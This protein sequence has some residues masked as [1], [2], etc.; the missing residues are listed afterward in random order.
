MR[1]T[2]RI[3]SAVISAMLVL[4]I[5]GTN[6]PSGVFEYAAA[7]DNSVTTLSASPAAQGS[8]WALSINADGTYTVTFSG[9][10]IPE[11]FI[12]SD[13]IAPYKNSITKVVVGE[14]VSSIGEAAFKGCESLISVDFEKN[15]VLKETG[16]SVFEGCTN[17]KKVNLENLTALEYIGTKDA[18]ACRLF[19]NSGLESVIIPASVKEIGDAAFSNSK[20][21]KVE[22][23]E[24]KVLT[25]LG[26]KDGEI[27]ANCTELTDID[28]TKIVS[29]SFSFGTGT[30]GYYPGFYGCTSLESITV[31]G[32]ISGN[33]SRVFYDCK[34]LKN[35][36]FETNTNNI[37]GI[38]E[39]IH[40]TKVEV[41]DLTPLNI[42]DINGTIMRDCKSVSTLKLPDTIKNVTESDTV[43]NCPNLKEIIW[44]KNTNGPAFSG[45]GNFSGNPALED[46]GFDSLPDLTQITNNMFKGDVSLERAVIGDKVTSIGSG[47][48]SG[49][50]GLKEVVYKASS[51]GSVSANAFENAG[52]FDLKLTAADDGEF[53]SSISTDLLEAV[54]GHI[55]DII[56]DKNVSFTVG[57]EENNTGLP[58]P[59]TKGG[60][61]CTDNYGNVYH[62]TGGGSSDGF[63]ELVYGARNSDTLTIP[64]TVKCGDNNFSV[65]AI[66]KDAFKGSS[67]KSL[68]FESPDSITAIDDYAFA[69]AE[70]L[71]SINSESTQE[72]IK[73]S[74][75]GCADFG[76]NLFV[77]TLI[78]KDITEKPFENAEAKNDGA[79]GDAGTVGI[80]MSLED[81]NQIA[82][83]TAEYYTGQSAVISVA[84]SDNVNGVYRIYVRKESDGVAELNGYKLHST[85]DPNIWY[86]ELEKR[87]SGETNI[88]KLSLS[89]PNYTQ[90][91]RKMQVWGVKLS[92][93]VK[94]E[95]VG[96]VIEPGKYTTADGI[97]VTENYIEPTWIA[98]EQEF[99]VTK[100]IDDDDKKAIGFNA[101]DDD[102]IAIKNLRYE[103]KYSPVGD[104]VSGDCGNDFVK[105]VD[106]SDELTL[107]TGLKW[108]D[109]INASDTVFVSDGSSS[110]LYSVIDGKR[111]LI[112]TISGFSQNNGTVTDM[113]LENKDGKYIIHFRVANTK[114]D[115]EIS[116]ISG[117]I[118]FGDEVIFAK[119]LTESTSLKI[120]NNIKSETNYNFAEKKDS[121]DTADVE[122]DLGSAKVTFDKEMIT[123]TKPKYMGE[124]VEFKLTV[125]NPSP[126]E[127]ENLEKLEDTLTT[128]DNQLLYIKP[129]NMQA[130]FDGLH[131]EY[132]T[133]E[134]SDAVI[135]SPATGQVTALDGKTQG[136]ISAANTLKDH[137]KY[138][139]L[140]ESG[141]VNNKTI[142]ISKS[143]KNIVVETDG[144]TVTVG[145]SGTYKTIAEALD[146]LAYIVTMNDNYKLTWDYPDDYKLAAG[147]K[148]E[149]NVKATTKNSLMYLP[150]GDSL[151]YYD[152]LPGNPVYYHNKASLYHKTGS[153]DEVTTGQDSVSYDLS[154]SKDGKVNGVTINGNESGKSHKLQIGDI[155]DYSVDLTHRGKSCYD[156]LP[157][158][159]KMAGLQ[160]L[161]VPA[162]DNPELSEERL[163][164]KT[165][166]GVKYYVLKKPGTYKNIF[167][168]G[169][170]ADT[171]TVNKTATG[172][173][174]L[175][176]YYIVNDPEAVLDD[177]DGRTVSFC[178]KAVCDDEYI[179]GAATDPFTVNNEAWAN[180][181]PGHRI[182][183][184]IFTGGAALAYYKDIVASRGSE[185]KYDEI[186][187]DD[188]STISKENNTVT[189]R[190]KFENPFPPSAEDETKPEVYLSAKD[191]YDALP[192]TGAAFNWKK[193]TNV[194]I[195]YKFANGAKFVKGDTSGGFTALESDERTKTENNWEVANTKP[196]TSG[197]EAV[198]GKQYLQWN[199]EDNISVQ[200]PPKSQFYI[201]VTLTF[202]GDD[203]EWETYIEEKG[204][205]VLTNTLYVYNFPDRVTHSLSEPGKVLL[206]KGVYETGYYTKGAR[207]W[208][209]EY[210]RG[211]DRY[212]YTP[213]DPIFFNT[214]QTGEQKGAKNT[215]TYYLIIKN[216]GS[217]NLYLSDVYD[218]LPQG[219]EFYALRNSA[220]DFNGSI[221]FDSTG[222]WVSSAFTVGSRRNRGINSDNI[223]ERYIPTAPSYK[224]NEGMGKKMNTLVVTPSG[225]RT[226]VENNPDAWEDEASVNGEKMKFVLTH[227]GYEGE[228]TLAD[229]RKRIKFHFIKNGTEGLND[230]EGGYYSDEHKPDNIQTAKIGEDAVPYL[231]PGEFTQFAYT[232]FTAD[233]NDAEEKAVNYAAMEYIDT[234]GNTEVGL[235][236]ETGVDVAK[237]NG[238]ENNDGSRELWDNTKAQNAGFS[239]TS[240][241][242]KAEE[243]QWLVSGVT[244][245]KGDII[246]G[247]TKKVTGDD[248]L[249]KENGKESEVNWTVTSRNNGTDAMMD[250]VISDTLEPGFRFEG[251][252]KYEIH[253][254]SGPVSE[255]E[256]KRGNDCLLK[257]GIKE[258]APNP[259]VSGQPEDEGRGSDIMFHIKR[260]SDMSK[261][262]IYSNTMRDG[263]ETPVTVTANEGWTY[264]PNIYFYDTNNAGTEN[265]LNGNILAGAYVKFEQEG[266]GEKLH[267]TLKIR[268]AYKAGET[269]NIAAYAIPAGGYSVLKVDTVADKEVL[270]GMYLNNAYIIPSQ[271]F[272]NNDVSQGHP[273]T[274]DGEAAVQ[275]T[276]PVTFYQG[277]PTT[278]YKEIAEIGADG[279]ATDNTARS[280]KEENCILVSSKESKVR[281][282]LNI[283][284]SDEKDLDQLVV[285]DN[286][287]QVDDTVTV[288]AD[289]ADGNTLR[290]EL[291]RYSE[292]KVSLAGT[293]N[294]T[295]NIVHKDN[296]GTVTE[297]KTLDQDTD[298]KVQYSTKTSGFSGSDWE[299]NNNDDD[300]ATWK[301]DIDEIKRDGGEVRS[302]RF[303]IGNDIVKQGDKVEISFDAVIDDGAQPSQVAWNSFGYSYLV[304]SLRAQAAPLN[305]GVRI[306]S[307]P[308]IKKS[309]VT[310]RGGLSPISE[311]KT[312]RFLIYKGDEA[313]EF[314]DYTEVGLAEKL[315]PLYYKYTDYT[316]LKLSVKKGEDQSDIFDIST[317]YK[318]GISDLTSWD[319]IRHFYK[320]DDN[321]WVWEEGATYYILEIDD[322]ENE[323]LSFFDING[324]S[325]R[326]YKFT[327]DPSRNEEITIS[328]SKPDWNIRILKHNEY[329][330]PLEGALFG[331]YTPN[332]GEKMS[333][334]DFNALG[335]DEKYRTKSVVD[336]VTGEFKA[337]HLMDTGTS[338]ENG[339]LSWGGL[340][341]DSYLVYEITPPS[342]YDGSD[343]NYI[344]KRNEAD[345]TA[346]L[347]EIVVN[348]P[349]ITLPSA[350][351]RGTAPIKA[352]GAA[353]TIT[354]MILLY[355]C[356]CRKKKKAA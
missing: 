225:Y 131:G 57:T 8:G 14:R 220:A 116:Q 236:T 287:P 155:I 24:N 344:F 320:K 49:C 135:T 274:L 9:T 207:D 189:Y 13:E 120:T 92:D 349:A 134:I 333:D 142:T 123:E 268:F 277:T 355:F 200:F 296:T 77:N 127:Y 231:A 91:G 4:S 73:N 307:E 63:A 183:A 301:D 260:E 1:K 98:R 88:P 106:F 195:E 22:F 281:Y 97:Y 263:R 319:P 65:T 15:A 100:S 172:L 119:E 165:V 47:A 132:L 264:I 157:V 124:D 60:Q 36:T 283:Q 40:D 3:A 348:T 69:N 214:D 258:K 223:N 332:E 353:L 331:I 83:K 261:L 153:K 145:E 288:G 129:E 186:D 26:K 327:Y 137:T 310:S 147:K 32:N 336:D 52:S 315:A 187:S 248:L 163:P 51:L 190:L 74:F 144:K 31:P 351:G 341:E 270:P 305:V 192:E 350:G 178:Y 50:T 85:D 338:N 329:D 70:N 30:G 203:G 267:E 259:N 313:E 141:D 343:D 84:I 240:S 174:T 18:D 235:D 149:Y 76:S 122:L 239:E 252:V 228:E 180:D 210:Y 7:K 44:E 94:D 21:K 251:D 255:N 292:F 81:T 16:N 256:G 29:D 198:A 347:S 291:K 37:T 105:Y 25:K 309:I 221:N 175:I 71:E 107:P 253:G 110:S 273:T 237:Y 87:E 297:T 201:Y 219:F 271:K 150:K 115:E 286:L 109:D 93:T 167:I 206:Q 204:G 303:V 162:S 136:D 11:N 208:F 238:M 302:I 164:E 146:S 278:S 193:D 23:K 299:A 138:D 181:Y 12:E 324:R 156:V 160:C 168:G 171:V 128:T 279:N 62:L 75:T 55:D 176:K 216:S 35:I 125:E 182:Y 354:P 241:F 318:Y 48:F 68:T 53:P 102:T 169:I 117:D 330:S 326:Q 27:F 232:V 352:V 154:I 337:Y 38:T 262:L 188:F 215:V 246:P 213:N 209:T 108:R 151:Y 202:A 111:Y 342:G 66:G 80:E 152:Y 250:Y 185:P 10:S 177:K 234:T 43:V 33:L 194:S 113:S 280:D 6:F 133:I 226:A 269:E 46:F 284:N 61:Y 212:H 211:I 325:Q 321:P 314:N 159:D 249:E 64:S 275:S 276:A 222:T 308:Q 179:E 72:N 114:S 89:Y 285:I 317:L 356:N 86:F 139:G 197:A 295:I 59:F 166:D 140:A 103:I 300:Q 205:A 54:Q 101:V 95:Y 312:F 323:G 243:R 130:L 339:V 218:I 266:E 306:P 5:A 45:S 244:V 311:D 229:G 17:L 112:C 227:V 340:G 20:L 184:P 298:Y 90:P 158:V 41:L 118:L 245:E 304:E 224:N 67:V 126:F 173:E 230:T 28:L 272:D 345:P 78:G 265:Y 82:D 335:I 282:T 290:D 19:Y 316:L 143:G 79:I 58:A 196:H 257:C 42:T 294:F 334:D 170:C 199:W 254:N 34:S 322:E 242:N 328:N 104:T 99:N 217:T 191:F 56:I 121:T 96:K 39:I 2:K 148:L 161:L 293:P 346:T 247:I 289:G 233:N